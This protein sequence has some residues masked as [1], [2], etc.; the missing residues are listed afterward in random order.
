MIFLNLH[1]EFRFEH[2]EDVTPRQPSN[3]VS[4]SPTFKIFKSSYR[5]SCDVFDHDIVLKLCIESVDTSS[6]FLMRLL[7]D[8]AHFLFNIKQL[9]YKYTVYCALCFHD[10][11]KGGYIL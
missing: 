2:R 3:V 10:D 1:M 7:H 8:C 5:K 4:C 6:S 11:Q 9:R